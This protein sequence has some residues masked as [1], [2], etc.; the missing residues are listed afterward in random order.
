[1]FLFP[2]FK[3]YNNCDL[4]P[5]LY[6]LLNS[7]LNFDSD[8]KVKIKNLAK[9]GRTFVFNFDYP[10]STN[11]NKEEFET[12][13]L[14]HFLMRRI[15]YETFTAFQI[16]LN[17]KL[18]EIMPMYNKLYD[19]IANWNLFNDGETVTRQQTDA[20]TNTNITNNTVNE[21]IADTIANTSGSTGTNTSATTSDQR[22]SDTPQNQIADVRDGKYVSDYRYNQDNGTLTS[23]ETSTSNTTDNKTDNKTDNTTS[24]T[25]DNNLTNESIIRTQ[26]DKINIYKQFL[27]EKQNLY[28]MIFTDLDSLFFQVIT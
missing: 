19:S 7:K 18:N 1:M 10:L 26:H 11:W 9:D 25:T 12:M 27:E 22:H 15:G 24:N 13:I 23:T 2:L 3:V 28:T 16:A 20:R 6:A 17:V 8:E 5:T 14:N 4:P 21:T